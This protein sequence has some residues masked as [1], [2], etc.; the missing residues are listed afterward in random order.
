MRLF[1]GMG[2]A[3]EE[4]KGKKRK[5]GVMKNLAPTGR[6]TY[7]TSTTEKF[8]FFFSTTLTGTQVL[9]EQKA[10]Y[11]CNAS[12]CTLHRNCSILFFFSAISFLSS[13]NTAKRKI[14]V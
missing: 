13:V 10:D 6:Q 1:T 11:M 8:L 2:G 14:C 12:I 5:I 4:A 7:K 3:G 9:E